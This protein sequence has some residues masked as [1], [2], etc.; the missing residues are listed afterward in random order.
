MFILINAHALLN[1]PFLLFS[2][3]IVLT[4]KNCQSSDEK[5]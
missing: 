3:Y 4:C 1:A 2:E 5:S